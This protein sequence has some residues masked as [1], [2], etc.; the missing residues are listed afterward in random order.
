MAAGQQKEGMKIAVASA[1]GWP[2]VRRGNRFT[3]ELASYLARRGH[4]VHYITSKP[5]IIRR[6]KKEDGMT[7]EYHRLLNNP[8][9]H[10]IQVE[11][12]DTFVLPCIRSIVN[13]DF[14]IVQTILPMDGFAASM[15]KT[16]KGTPFV[17]YMIDSFQPSYYITKYGKFMLKKSVNSATRVTAPS[18]FIIDNV[19]KHFGIDALLT[20][21]PVDTDQFTICENKDLNHPR[22]LYT[23]SLHD[24]RKGFLLLV[25][26]F[27]KLLDYVPGATLQL[28]GH[29][30][31]KAIEVI[32]KSVRS[33][34]RKAIDV[35]GVGK[36]EDL[37]GLY[38][39][40]AVTVLPSVN[41]AFGMVLLESLA[42][43]TPVVGLKSGGIPDIFSNNEIGIL[44][45]PQGGP[46][47]LCKAIMEGLELSQD[48]DVWK[49]CRNHAESFSWN[50]IGPRYEKL[51]SEILDPQKEVRV[52]KHSKNKEVSRRPTE[53]QT[54]QVQSNEAVLSRIFDDALDKIEI[55][56]DNY[57]R[58]DRHKPFCIFIA[59]WL[60]NHALQGSKVLAVGDF[61]FPLNLLLEK[62]GFSV[63]EIKIRQRHEP[64][65]D[66]GNQTFLSD[67][68]SLKDECS[69]YD[70]IICDEILHYC[71][72]PVRT[73]QVLRDKL[74]P[75]G[76][77][78][79]AVE[80]AA[81]GKARLRLLTGKSIYP[82]LENDLLVESI[83]TD[84]EK[85][86]VGYRGYILED[87]ERLVS[88]AGFSLRT[89]HYIMREKAVE[90]S[91]FPIPVFLYFHRTLFYL[92]RKAI[93]HFRSH[94]FVAARRKS[95]P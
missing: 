88:D 58:V 11:N 50:Q 37:P 10:L 4:Q 67:I 79:L 44:S 51:Y 35:L 24:P 16:I 68:Q 59:K 17:H 90:G 86:V 66:L 9:L 82:D 76:T 69:Q 40:A 56:Y 85:R 84:V 5:G 13:N 42:S 28:S 23:S 43:G 19:K 78:I 87:L 31:P 89:S 1:L 18:N 93:P 80:N 71:E 32:Y 8:L 57:Y 64:W 65:K 61:T 73:L 46:E 36:R 74:S 7:I 22:I 14:D 33:K 26:A 92:V 29:A 60:L 27:E 77:L 70:I 54:M 75:Q 52:R 49:K 62:C 45:E 47:E 39:E 83:S 12:L 38:R 30:H 34:A 91:L 48:P 95:S 63:Q 21:P 94:I 55:D 6:N 41:E 2:Y 3:Y 20:P 81:N 25:K 72:S 53:Q 15:A